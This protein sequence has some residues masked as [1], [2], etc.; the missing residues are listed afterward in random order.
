MHVL[1]ELDMLIIS[2]NKL[3]VFTY[4]NGVFNILYEGV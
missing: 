1:I 3:Y 4:W 2:K